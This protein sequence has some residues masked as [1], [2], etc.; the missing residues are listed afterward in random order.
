MTSDDQFFFDYLASIPNDV[1][2]YSTQVADSIDRQFDHAATVIRDTLSHQSWLPQAVRPMRTS[3]N[4]RAPRGLADRVQDWMIRNRA[5]TAAIAAFLGTG[6]VLYYGSKKLHGK[7]RKARK[8]GNGARK[9]IVVIAGSPHEP[10]TRAMAADLERRGYIVYVT[11]SSA[12]EEHIVQSE[13]RA[14]IK[15]LWLD[16]TTSS[17]MPSE[18][19]PSL[20]ELRDLITQPQYPHPGMPPHT[21]QLSGI[22]IV[23]SPNYA[24]GPV[25]TIPPS[26]WADT[27]NT[28]LLSPILTAQIFLPLLTLRS[29]SST[30]AFVYPS[31]SSSLSA[32]FAGPE[33]TSTRAISGF[34]TSLRQELRLLE[35]ANVDVVELRLGNIDLGPSYRSAQS[36]VAGT[37][38]LAWSVQQRA[39]YGQQYLSSVEQRPVASAG[40]AAIRGSPARHLHHAVLDALE[41]ASRN[42]L[43][44]RKSKKAVMYVGRGARSY[45]VIGAWVPSGLVGLMMGYRSGNGAVSPSVGSENSWEQV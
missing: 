9:E 12:D 36:Q 13:S 6:C 26:S 32:P 27:V 30:I 42:F 16:L 7:R 4:A 10:M 14:D 33:V 18:I 5:W 8:A 44:Q 11:V 40:P 1:R 45:N 19:H 17:P 34:A 3:R 39:L 15:P 23:P 29:N 21:C 43:G 24:A 25:A 22:F 35:N 41:P 20:H 31:I 28:R 2:H 38:V 37:E